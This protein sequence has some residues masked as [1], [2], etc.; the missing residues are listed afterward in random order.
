MRTKK[1]IPVA[2][3]LTFDH[4]K[5]Q[6]SIR[7]EM[8]LATVGIF[9]DGIACSKIDDVLNGKYITAITVLPATGAGAGAGAR[10]GAKEETLPFVFVCS[11]GAGARFEA[12]IPR[13]A[14]VGDVKTEVANKLGIL[15]G[16]FDLE[17]NEELYI[18][19]D[20]TAETLYNATLSGTGGLSRTVPLCVIVSLR[21]P[22]ST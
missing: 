16:A 10:A 6:V 14:N 8:D 22:K 13:D 11:G 18:E 1:E 2:Q 12:R 7:F 19:E 17:V 15:K 21:Q 3:G 5:V 20:T 4:F 9:A